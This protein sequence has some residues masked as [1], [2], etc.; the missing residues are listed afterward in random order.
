MGRRIA[1]DQLLGISALAAPGAAKN[2]M[3]ILIGGD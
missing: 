1:C 3:G 2:Q